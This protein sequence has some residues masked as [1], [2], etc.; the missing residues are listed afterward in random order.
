MITPSLKTF[1]T[2]SNRSY[3]RHKYELV[4]IDGRSVV[5]DDY[6]AMREAWFQ[7]TSVCSHVNVVDKKKS[8]GRGF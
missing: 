7:H 8:R 6:S 4:F 1:T 5:I 2:T 3:D